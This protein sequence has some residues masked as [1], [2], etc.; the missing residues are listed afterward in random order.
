MFYV[1]G[2]SEN[3]VLATTGSSSGWRRS[4]RPS[5]AAGTHRWVEGERFYDPHELSKYRETEYPFTIE[6]YGYKYQGKTGDYIDDHI[7]AYGA[8]EKD[9]LYFMRDYVEARK[10]PD[11][12]FLDVVPARGS[13]RCSCRAW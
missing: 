4:S 1:L 8:Y 6:V 3:P 5:L 10:N 11:A 12:V 7:L 9:V 13:T 2:M